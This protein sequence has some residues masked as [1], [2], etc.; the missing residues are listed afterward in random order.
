MG[1]LPP[2]HVRRT[3]RRRFVPKEL[4]TDHAINEMETPENRDVEPFVIAQRIGRDR[5]RLQAETL[6]VAATGGAAL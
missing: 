3:T 4:A 1:R 2:A 5:F 6:Q